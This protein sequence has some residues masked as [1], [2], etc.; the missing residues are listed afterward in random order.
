MKN[1]C[2]IIRDILPLYAEKMVSNDTAEFVREH[3][4]ICP[5]CR[6]ELEK[7]KEPVQPEPDIDAAPLKRL[8][9]TAA[10]KESENYPLYD[11]SVACIDAVSFRFFDSTGVFHL[12]SG[13]SYSNRCR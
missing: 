13:F 1:E 11:S 4:E 5:A 12:F 6:A 9:K 2:N 3:L 8:K 7:M 10:G